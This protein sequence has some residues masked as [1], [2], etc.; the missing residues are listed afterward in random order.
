M[1]DQ[2]DDLKN[3]IIHVSSTLNSDVVILK[4]VSKTS[5][6]SNKRKTRCAVFFSVIWI[7]ARSENRCDLG[8]VTEFLIRA[9]MIDILRDDRTL[10]C[11]DFR[12]ESFLTVK[13]NF[14]HWSNRRIDLHWI[15]S[16]FEA[17]TWK[18]K[19]SSQSHLC[20]KHWLR[21]RSNKTCDVSIAMKFEK[22]IMTSFFFFLDMWRSTFELRRK[23]MI[24]KLF[25]WRNEIKRVRIKRRKWKNEF[26]VR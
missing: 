26:F 11:I 12:N 22:M 25:N 21:I 8:L 15:P 4:V 18:K 3:D 7:T 14:R 23:V 10:K 17:R 5:L 20:W 9:K 1:H 16:I 19:S 6:K 2:S 24:E 13:K